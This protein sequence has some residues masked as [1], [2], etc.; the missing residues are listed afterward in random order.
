MPSAFGINSIAS[1]ILTLI[2]F[3]CI[4][5]LVGKFGK[6]PLIITSAAFSLVATS[7]L[8]FFFVENV[9]VFIALYNIATIANIFFTMMVWALVT[10]CLDYTE[11][12]TGK[13][14]DG[15]LYSIYSFAR[16]LGM[17]FGAALTSYGLGWAGFVSGA[18]TQ[19]VEV[20]ENIV[21]IYTL[22]PIIAFVFI[23]IGVGLI[24]NLSNKKADEMYKALEARRTAKMQDSSAKTEAL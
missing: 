11:F 13:R 12:K 17:G 22:V 10:D 4:P 5:K 9:F 21:R 6:K 3:V 19:T 23:L 18:N 24:F 15:T 20:A 14:Y 16:K 1:I 8:F 2:L 7:L